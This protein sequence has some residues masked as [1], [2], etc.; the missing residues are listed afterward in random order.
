MEHYATSLQHILAELERV[1][2]LIRAQVWRARQG[3]K[4]DGEFQ[5][6][7]ISEQEIDALLAQ[8]VGLPR[9]ATAP[10]PL[11]LAEVR[12]ALDRM[13]V[14]IARRKAE[15]A[16]RGIT[17][18]LD[19]LA[20][21]FQLTPFDIDA[22]LIC[23][24]PELDLRYERLYA[25]LQ[26]DVTK[27]RPSVDLVLNLLCPSFEAKL[28][29]RPRF[30]PMAPLIRHRL[31]T[32]YAEMPERHPPLLAHFLK[33]DERIV[34][35]L[36]GSDQ[37][38]ARLLP[39]V[40]WREPQVPW[41]DLILPEDVKG[42][43][44]QLVRWYGEAGAPAS[45]SDGRC[46]GLIL[47]FQGP[48]G[49]GKQ[50]TMEALCRELGIPLL[51]IDTARLLQGNLPFETAARL[52]FRE[53][54]LQQAVLCFDRF[55]LLLVEDDKVRQCRETVIEEMEHLSGLTFLAGWVGW[56]PAG[57][58]HRKAFIRVELPLPPYALRKQLWE[59]S[60]NGLM[61]S[62]LDLGALANK[63]HL[64]A[65]QI[66]D[67]VATARNLARWR[68]PANGHLTSDDLYNACRAHSNQKL[69]ILAL[70]IFPKYTWNDIVLPKEQ[71][72]QLRE[73][74]NSVKYRHLVYGDW[75]FDRKLSLGKGLNVLFTGPSGT[76]KTMAA[77]IMAG[78]LGMDLYKIDLSTVVSKYIGETEKNLARIFAEAETSNAILFFDEAD[79]LFGK[80][81]EVKDAH[82]RYANIE[83]S[84][85]LQ[86]MEEYEG[87]V[88]LAT[89]LRKNMD[90]A[91]VRRMH[92]TVEFPFPEE[93]YRRQIW[94]GMFPK[95]APL[96]SDIDF[97]FLARQ[98][99]LAGGNIKNI[100]L[101]AAF[102]AAEDG[103]PIG[104]AHLIR[105]TKREF[106]KMGR[107]CS[108]ADFMG[109]YDLIK[110]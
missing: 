8:P 21:L 89:N 93:E 42:R 73:I 86:K 31:L 70:R 24:A 26:D 55:D 13:A 85:L 71:M 16:R 53:A 2:L 74:V 37:T 69:S 80:R 63:F 6:L 92:S 106:Q 7:Y 90:E 50:A 83:T 29:A 1:D 30:A 81:S 66:R 39:C 56:E 78:E 43:L 3:Q 46:E 25:Y 9:W 72:G 27:K 51:V 34:Q 67:T 48:S 59:A 79:A 75:G 109:Y 104:M 19:E 68:D 94:E 47:Y 4:A 87:V 44:E 96:G 91:F 57:A 101:H 110:A 52:I 105:A 23:L 82:D 10:T 35:Y 11:S 28:A 32:V 41:R 76:G 88:I 108:E 38:D 18:R 33:V 99:K 107:L 5:G 102:L 60:L 15:S 95:E 100:A 12:A 54:L 17:L 22:L 49:V 98:F 64:S 65:G 20:R 77:E 58:F 14:D 61:S 84:Y 45:Q 40:R 97:A 62:N 36:L 103:K